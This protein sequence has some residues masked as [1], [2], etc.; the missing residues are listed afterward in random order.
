MLR[1]TNRCR[2]CGLEQRYGVA[3]L[4]LSEGMATRGY[5][6]AWGLFHMIYE[7]KGYWFRTPEAWDITGISAPPCT[8]VRQR[9]GR[10]R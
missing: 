9:S 7:S 5:R 1:I 10:W 2:K 8:C 3:A 6:T 4:M